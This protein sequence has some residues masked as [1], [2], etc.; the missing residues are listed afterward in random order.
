MIVI[1]CARSDKWLGQGRN[2]QTPNLDRLCKGGIVFPNTITEKSFTTPAFATMITGLYSRRHGIQMAWGNRIDE[3]LPALPHLLMDQG[4]KT[5]AE[6]T[7]PLIPEMGFTWAFNHYEYRAPCDCIDSKWGDIFIKHLSSQYYQNPWFIL[8][9]LF[10]LHE[11]RQ[12]NSKYNQ[13]S[14]GRNDYEKAVSSLDRQLGKIFNVLL[15]DTLIVVT[16]DHGEK[17]K[18]EKYQ[19]GTTVPYIEKYMNLDHSMGISLERFVKFAGPGVLQQMCTQWLEEM[20]HIDL[21]GNNSN[22]K[23]KLLVT[24]GDIF[25]SLMFLPK[26]HVMD[27]FKIG[28]PLKLTEMLKERGL[29]EK[30]KSKEKVDKIVKLFGSE[31]VINM[32]IRMW[33]NSY[34]KNSREGHGVH[35]Y[36]YLV[37]VPLVIHYPKNLSSVYCSNMVRQPD[38]LPT[39]ID[40]LSIDVSKIGNIDGRSLRPLIEGKR[41]SIQPAYLSVTGG[42]RELELHGV[43]TE[44][45]K[46]TFG[47]YNPEMPEELYD[48]NNDPEEMCNIA[49]A[50][51]EC[52]KKLRSIVNNFTLTES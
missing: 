47:P 28:H 11:P 23:N 10:E 9:H 41:M 34:K 19:I 15:D 37:R 24:I 3:K 52:C 44:S 42:P 48:L 39:I 8:L 17:T 43:R 18:D 35:V 40:L 33:I 30:Q 7:G 13:S 49:A 50:D 45:Y 4:Y 1:D 2:T 25:L 51:P 46:Y 21:Y 31:A 22:S 6:V 26:L 27:I 5:Y 20:N 29:L 14:Y 36:D 38:I 16:G 12:I 32:Q